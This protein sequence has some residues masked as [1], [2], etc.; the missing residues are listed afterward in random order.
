MRRIPLI[1]TN[2]S[3]RPMDI[4]VHYRQ[5]LNSKIG[6]VNEITHGWYGGGVNN[7]LGRPTEF[8]SVDRILFAN[9]T[10][11][12]LVRGNM[13]TTRGHGSGTSNF[14]DGWI[15]G[16][17][18]TQNTQYTSRIDRITFVTDGSVA[19]L[20]GPISLAR[21]NTAAV[22]NTTDGWITGGTTDSSGMPPGRSI[23]DRIIFSAD[24]STTSVRNPL[25]Q[26]ISAHA[27]ASNTSAGWLFSGYAATFPVSNVYRLTFA[28]DTSALSTRGPIQV[29]RNNHD[30]AWNSQNAWI[31]GGGNGIDQAGFQQVERMTFASD[32]SA[33]SFRGTLN[34]VNG[35]CS[36]S[37]NS[38]DA[39]VG[40]GYEFTTLASYSSIDRI[41]FAN[42]TSVAVRRGS[43]S[44]F[45]GALV[46]P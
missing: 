2:T 41:I 24:L 11:T 42:D 17:V 40:G 32:T 1:V 12:A 7:N 18:L 28:N 4:D 33:T 29:I 10:T 6:T 35:S 8:S 27:S 36:T 16:G 20:R 14:T 45:R 30:A 3:K 39:W 15:A 38:T 46:S 43:L 5:L 21:H 37:L 34:R 26:G 9:D 23:V 19:L 13:T 22:G 31:Y 25:P 44:V